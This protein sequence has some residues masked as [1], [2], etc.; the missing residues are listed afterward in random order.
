MNAA[1]LTATSSN[2]NRTP[3]T[4]FMLFNQRTNENDEPER[5]TSQL[6]GLH[7]A[8]SHLAPRTSHLALPHLIVLRPSFSVEVI[9]QDDRGRG[10]VELLFAFP[11]ITLADREAA[12]GLAARQS[13]VFPGNGDSRASRQRR[14]KRDDARRL[15]RR[16]AVQPRR[17]PDDH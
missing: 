16:R 12:L 15:A 3:S 17:H 2:S 11:P 6:A 5:R 9:L 4:F 8:P 14:D 10:C 7:L 1:A 13:L